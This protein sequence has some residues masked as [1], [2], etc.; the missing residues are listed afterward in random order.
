MPHILPGHAACVNYVVFAPSTA[1]TEGVEIASASTD[2]SVIIWSLD[3]AAKGTIYPL[4][5]KVNFSQHPSLLVCSTM[6]QL[7]DPS[8][9]GLWMRLPKVGFVYQP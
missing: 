6:P 9:S 4:N 7:M 5:N 1:T 2:G 3:E 8:S